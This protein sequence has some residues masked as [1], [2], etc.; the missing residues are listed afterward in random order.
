MK[1][2]IIR[3]LLCIL[4]LAVS[5]SMYAGEAP[6]EFTGPTWWDFRDKNFSIEG[7][8]T[9]LNPIVINT[10]EELAQLSYLNYNYTPQEA[11]KEKVVVLDADINLN[12]TVNG[13]RVQWIPIG[14]KYMFTGI[15]LGVNPSKMGNSDLSSAQRH[16][17]SGMYI[18]MS[19]SDAANIK[20][21]KGF[22]LF[23][24]IYGYAGYVNITDA[25][26][27]VD[28]S[29]STA[30]MWVGI[31]SGI[32]NGTAQKYETAPSKSITVNPAIDAVSVSGILNV[33]GNTNQTFGVGG[34]TAAFGHYGIFHSTSE[35]S[36]NAT[37]CNHVGGIVGSHQQTYQDITI[38]AITDCSATANITCTYEGTAKNAYAGGI[39]GEAHNSKPMSIYACSSAGS[40]N[41]AGQFY[42]G[43]ISGNM[44]NTFIKGCASMVNLSGNGELGGIVGHMEEVSS[45]DIELT[46][47]TYSGHIDATQA[48]YAGGLCGYM[49]R[50]DTEEHINGCLFTGTMAYT[51][52]ATNYSVTV[53]ACSNPDNLKQNL[54]YCYFDKTLYN[55]N[56]APGMATLASFQVKGLTTEELTSADVSKLEFLSTDKSA[57]HGFRLTKGF[58]PE[59]Y[60]N[61]TSYVPEY[62]YYALQGENDGNGQSEIVRQLFCSSYIY[63]DNTVYRTGTW[64]CSLPFVIPKGDV[65]YDLVTHVVAPSR[66]AEWSEQNR[67]I[68]LSSKYAFQNLPCIKVSNDTAFVAANGTFTATL[69]AKPDRPTAVWNRPLPFSQSKTLS[70]VST[71]DQVWDGTTATS[72]A[73]GTGTK[74]DPFLIKNGAQLAYAVKSNKVG[75]CFKQ[76][77]DINLNS[78]LLNYSK[79]YISYNSEKKVWLSDGYSWNPKDIVWSA[80]YDGDGHVIRGVRI[81]R[82]NFGTFG[83]IDADGVVANLGVIDSYISVRSGLLAYEMN[84]TIR[85]CV[86]QGL[87]C[88]NHFNDT[89]SH[90][91][92][93]GGI[94]ALVGTTN[95]HAT[96]ED[97]VSAMYSNCT[98][99]DYTPFVSI[100][101]SDAT[102]Q[103]QGK[104]RNCLAVVPTSFGDAD[105]NDNYTAAGH[106]FIENCYWLKGYEP[107]ATGYTLEELATELGKR[108]GWTSNKGYFPMLKSFAK[109]D[110]GKL[111]SI[112]VRTDQGY[113]DSSYNQFLLGFDR[114]LLFEPGLASWS[115]NDDFYVEADG[116]MGIIVPK[117]ASY[118]YDNPHQVITRYVL[119][120]QQIIA[121]LGKETIAIPVRTQG[122][123]INPGI[124]FVDENARQACLDAFDSDKNGILS[125]AELKAVTNAQTLSAFQTPTAKRMVQFPEFRFFKNVTELTTQLN[126]L[127]QL[128]EVQ[129][130]YALTTIAGGESDE[131][132]AFYGCKSLKSLT[133]PAKVTG[134][135]GHPFYGSAIENITID[136]MNADFVSRNGVLFDVNNVLLAYPNGRAGEEVVFEGTINEIAKDAIYKID[137]LKNVFFETEDY[138]TVPYLNEN[139]IVS[140]DNELMDVYVS[141]ATYGSVLMQ[142]YSNDASWN[143]YVNA[144]KLHCYYP[145]RIGNAKAATLYIGFDT[146]LP[147]ALTPY[148][149]IATN[150]IDNTA[151]LKQMSRKV[152]HLSPIVIFAT[153][154]GLYRLKP[155]DTQLDPWKMYENRLNG[156]GRDGMPVYQ[157]D[158]D[159]GS[160]LTL[161]RNSN[162]DLGFYYYKGERIPPYRAYLTYEDI[163][164]PNA[165]FR[166]VFDDDSDETVNID[167]VSLHDSHSTLYDLQGRPVES[168]TAKPGIYIWNGRKV[169]KK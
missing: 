69:T 169:L 70:M 64:L 100:P 79:S 159:R 74:E 71:I 135:S 165:H 92:Y 33:V 94:C 65:A 22:G 63:K 120:Q 81:T 14:Y 98:L 9:W 110:I 164:D 85:N 60:N 156:V 7:K 167:N 26:I 127:S 42:A 160:I 140:T 10:P 117:K 38:H 84:G 102:L 66:N 59:V 35:V 101:E 4:G 95:A 5:A 134:I 32:S 142:G 56:I 96:V 150:D 109:T 2:P 1:K 82:K 30:N 17:I 146:Q 12:K 78:Q 163:I 151:T 125:L 68:K 123:I 89:D 24:R 158:S 6:A 27:S 153:Q 29:N 61:N 57:S 133:I 130:P 108:S 116:D 115:S 93:S 34:V 73:A 113:D 97:C 106:D 20:T 51:P 103:N 147:S 43:G 129:L 50:N 15:F 161:G 114:Q 53:G 118:D 145:L 111:L 37:N 136:P 52:E 83:N 144:N 131:T 87:A 143:E 39:V 58:Y 46:C 104:V 149:I 44:L 122:G 91:G 21:Q 99:K 137:G 107:T 141:D 25:S 54:T 49:D 152:P 162:G 72:F 40:I 47:C 166:F 80:Q 139:G 105:F 119:G 121:N 124:S 75:Q 62:D 19:A 86:V 23:S 13:Q 112:P 148:T 168:H 18:N 36:I 77:C 31:L 154:P 155:T 67:S 3:I 45:S 126:G 157:S 88:P 132:S 41:C 138:N 8:G 76:I 90:L 55:S 11:V 28:L 128:E 48:T 16:T